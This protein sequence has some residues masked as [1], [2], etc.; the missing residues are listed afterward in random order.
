MGEK[1]DALLSHLADVQNLSRAASVLS[2]DQQTGMPHGGAAAR[3]AQLTT[4]SRLHHTLF[5]GD[6]TAELLDAAANEI[7]DADYDSNEASLIRVV[8][9]DYEEATRLPEDVVSKLT[10]ATA[11]SHHAWAKARENNDFQAFLPALEKVVGLTR[12]AAEHIGYEETP[13]DALLTKYERGINTAQIKEIFD[14]HKPQLVELIAAISQNKDAVDNSILKQDFAVD[15][16]REFAL[17][18]V[19]RY[20]FDFER[21]LQ[22][23]SV[24][25]FC[26]NFSRDDVRMT[27]R[28]SPDFLNPALFGL[29]HETGHGLYEQ[30][31]SPALDAT[32]L[33]GGTSLG[34]HE[35]QSRLWENIVGRSKGFWSWALPQ[36]KETFPDQLGNVELDTFYKAINKVEPSY[37]RVE[38]DEATYNLHI[39]LRFELE[40]DI[41]AGRVK[42]QDLPQEWNARFE[43]FF[44]IVPPTDSE[45]VLQ[46]IHWSMGL[47]GYF[48]TYALGNLLSVQYYN[49]ALSVHPEIPDQIA[50]GQFDTL[51]NWMTDNIYQHG[52][53]Y[54]SDELTR[55]ITG[56]G[57]Q[58]RDYIAY[59]QKKFGEIYGL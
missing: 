30:G 42:L 24:H 41:I 10:E 19:K 49:K 52:R 20:G 50:N 16:Q 45:G 3:A 11:L 6:K 15:R 32:P 56:E 21:G 8:R 4:L 31:V 59:L 18:V 55:R 44:G 40:V 14:S 33:A 1:Y 34:V 12:E 43:Q 57:I 53:K 47:L 54:T 17:S 7:G 48:A 28:F 13:Y 27:T 22:A 23:E 26:T 58:S 35:S 46:D 25:P 9:Q 36:L 39:M 51:R 37:I 5:T 38:A 2:W 29:M